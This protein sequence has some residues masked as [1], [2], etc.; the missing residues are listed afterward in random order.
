[1]GLAAI[2]MAP[3]DAPVPGPDPGSNAPPVAVCATDESSN[4]STNLAIA[5]TVAGPGQVT[6][7]A[8]GVTV[9]TS[10]FDTGTSGSTT[11]PLVDV[12]AVGRAAALVEFP[13]SD[14]AAASIVAGDTSLAGELC[15]RVP[16]RL[17]VIGGG[18]TIED[19]QFEV[20]L[21]NPYS[22]EAVVDIRATSESGRESNEMLDA[23]TVP[24]RTSVVVDMDGLL[25]GRAQLV[26]EIETTRGNVVATARSDVLGDMAIWRAVAPTESSY[27]VFPSFAGS[28]EVFIS[29]AAP[30]DIEYQI[31]IYGPGGVDEAAIEGVLSAGGQDVI[32]LSLIS[33]AA[34][35]LHVVSTGPVG[36]FASLASESGLALTAGS[37]LAAANWLLPGAGAIPAS[38]GRLVMV[39]VGLEAAV[40][41]VVEVRNATR[42]RVV[43]VEPDQVLELELDE[44]VGDG[45]SLASDGLLVPIWVMATGEAVAMSGGLP[46]FNE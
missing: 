40:T 38:T 13:N 44:I 41:T 26:L 45:V 3:P 10:D 21:M 6:V 32:D 43:T 5:S 17:A 19:R 31:D 9:G 27:A 46:L 11:V 4:R 24:P 1:M 20:Q 16:D 23:I 18:S 2:V 30:T 39:N 29:S 33:E 14:S 36:V 15:S 12:S 42:S 37:P 35:A 34:V 22:A 7:F 25:P 8:G 28:R